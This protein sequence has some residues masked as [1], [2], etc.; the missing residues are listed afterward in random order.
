[1]AA[2]V[3]LSQT[4]IGRLLAGTR[5]LSVSLV[6]R[7]SQ[8]LD[9]PV[10]ALFLSMKD[11]SLLYDRRLTAEENRKLENSMYDFREEMIARLIRE[12]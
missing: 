3:G 10:S 12:K 9:I 6:E 4:Y 2:Y 8:V 11:Y 7:F 5:N 1:M